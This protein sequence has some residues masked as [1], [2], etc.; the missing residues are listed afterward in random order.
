MIEFNMYEWIVIGVG[1]F[2]LVCM[3]VAEWILGQ[4]GCCRNCCQGRKCR[5]GDEE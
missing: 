1:G 5:C 2:I 3:V 4:V